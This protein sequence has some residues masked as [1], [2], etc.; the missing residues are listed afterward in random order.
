MGDD[1]SRP[2]NRACPDGN[3]AADGR[4]CTDPDV[5]LQRDRCCGANAVAALLWGDGMTGAG[6][7]YAGGNKGTCSDVYRRG[8]Q[9]DIVIVDDRQAVSMDVEAIVTVEVRLNAGHGRACAQQG[10]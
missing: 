7:A 3:A 10:L 2:D 4:I 8:I 1:A 9:N 5:F 6:K